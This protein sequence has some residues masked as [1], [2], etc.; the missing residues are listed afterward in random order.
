MSE[1]VTS[2]EIPGVAKL[3]SLGLSSTVPV[4]KRASNGT[5]QAKDIL[6]VFIF[7]NAYFQ[8][9]ITKIYQWTMHNL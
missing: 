2:S 4:L 5:H 3:M 7:R 1:A 8:A 9:A 6:L